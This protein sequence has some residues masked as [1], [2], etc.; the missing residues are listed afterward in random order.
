MSNTSMSVAV[1]L[2]F[3]SKNSDK[4]ESVLQRNAATTYATYV[5]AK[6]Q[7]EDEFTD[8]RLVMKLLLHNMAV[9]AGRI[10]EDDDRLV[11]VYN[12]M[13]Q[14]EIFQEA[15]NRRHD[16]VSFPIVEDNQPYTPTYFSVDNN[17]NGTPEQG[18]DGFCRQ[19]FQKMYEQYIGHL[20]ENYRIKM[21][22]PR[23]C[24]VA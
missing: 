14:E 4:P 3:A 22:I 15:W 13:M 8:N 11:Y 18:N 23:F 1:M 17:L 2:L 7:F 24:K 9:A 19:W 5:Y 16:F 21:G 6:P 20:S 10:P 12:P